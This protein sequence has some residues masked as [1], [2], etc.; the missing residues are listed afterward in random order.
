[1]LPVKILGGQPAATDEVRRSALLEKML[2]VQSVWLVDATGLATG[3]FKDYEAIVIMAMAAELN[4][5]F[6]SVHSTGNT[7]LAYRH[8]AEELGVRCAI[9]VPAANMS[10]LDGL[11][12][13]TDWPVVAVDG[14]YKQFSAIARSVAA[15]R[16]WHHL[17]PLPWKLEG[18]AALAW[19][20]YENCPQVDLIVQ[21]IAGG[22][23]PLGMELGFRRL[24]AVG[25]FYGVASRR[26]YLLLQPSDADGIAR[27]WR[28]G[29]SRIEPCD[30]PLPELPFE[31]TLQSA[32]PNTTLPHLRR[33]LPRGTRI[34][35][36]SESLVAKHYPTAHRA[37]LEA[38][39]P[40]SYER[41]KSAYI[42]LAGLLEARLE[43]TSN[44]AVIVTGS[45]PF[46]AP[47]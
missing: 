12:D 29:S 44:V 40:V 30:I 20:I 35:S 45:R 47:R 5:D 23:G 3:T 6:V 4:L 9:I 27:A 19:M 17:A 37:F 39:I 22:F 32:N 36:V 31:P 11:P 24:A 15:E 26:R 18:K 46:R 33:N 13:L 34:G 28:K 21:T 14:P 8:Y 43:P 7:V 16:G 1:M 38:D 41:E 42:A 25:E 2:G 10:K